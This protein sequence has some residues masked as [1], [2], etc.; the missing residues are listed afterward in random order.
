MT[1]S[2]YLVLPAKQTPEFESRWEGPAWQG[3][4]SIEIG[5]FRPEGSG[6]RPLARCKLL[7]DRHRIYG[8]F[9]VED[10]Y[11][12]SVHTEFQDDVYQDSCV[13]FFVLPKAGFGYFNFEFNCGGAM[14]A[15][16]V[17]DPTRVEGRV[18]RCVPLSYE[19]GRRVRIGHSLP[20]IVEP[21]I[22]EETVWHLEFCV[23][24]TLLE[25]FVGP[26]RP[27]DGLT[28]Q[29][30]FYKCGDRTSH[31]HWASWS[32]LDALNFHA[33]WNF[34]SIRFVPAKDVSLPVTRF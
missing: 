3:V 31:R 6:H 9:M 23:P 22:E 30:N 12:H 33:P 16:Y 10:R 27:V 18:A 17:I 26:V 29:A 28:W 25:E 24:F 4:P 32:P 21:E 2:G 1:T 8:H 13:E 20:R 19:Q 7:Y 14:L 5:H 15:S 11:V 34:G